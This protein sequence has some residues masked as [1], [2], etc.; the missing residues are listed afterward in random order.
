MSSEQRE[1]IRSM[2]P[3]LLLCTLLITVHLYRFSSG[4]GLMHYGVFPRSTNQWTGIFTFPFI[5]EDWEH[6]ISNT[7]PLFILFALLRYHYS[8]VWLK[9]A[10]LNWILSGTWLWLG[11]RS[12]VHIGASGFVYG[13]AS[14]LFFSGL[15][16]WGERRS[17]AVSLVVVFLYGGL[18]WGLF[19]FLKE[20]SWEG[21][22]FGGLSGFLLAW[23]N[24]KAPPQRMVYDWEL[25]TDEA[26]ESDEPDHGGV[27]EF[28]NEAERVAEVPLEDAHAGDIIPGVTRSWNY[29][30]LPQDKSESTNEKPADEPI[31][32]H[33]RQNG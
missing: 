11:G 8:T 14:F 28:P 25:E 21:H 5:H 33:E 18:V 30:Y 9:V 31:P 1:V 23:S 20:M 6:L 26:E 22:L 3:G 24:R 15:W 32:P 17:M 10:L 16:R 4:E 13:L 19:P 7:V 27:N 2:L 12:A 29:V